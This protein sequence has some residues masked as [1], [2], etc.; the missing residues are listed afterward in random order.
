MDKLEFSPDA[1]D[2]WEHY[3]SRDRFLAEYI[4]EMFDRIESGDEPGRL[5]DDK[6]RFV[7][8]EIPGRDDLYVIAWEKREDHLYVTRVGRIAT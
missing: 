4:D 2:A 5:R 3:L 8:L 6:T 1:D 7:V